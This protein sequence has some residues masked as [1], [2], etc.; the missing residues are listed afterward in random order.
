MTKFI[1]TPTAENTFQISYTSPDFDLGEILEDSR[2]MEYRGDIELACN[3][4]YD[5]F[6]QFMSSIPDDEEI[7]L[8]WECEDSQNALQ[9]IN[10]SAID[11]FLVG[12]FE[13]CAAMLEFILELDPEDH[14]EATKRLAY[15]YIALEEYEL[16]DEIINDIS[17]KHVEKGILIIWSEYRRT[18]KIDMGEVIRM[19]SRFGVYYDEF[20]RDEHPITDHYQTDIENERPTRESL[21]RELW[22][23]TEHLWA[24]H[25]EFIQS[26]RGCGAA[27]A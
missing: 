10:Q 5:A 16:Y 6:Q 11:H 14:L 7:V 18:G 13:M 12:D 3:T 19:K 24:L 23:Q 26:L 27:R 2:K 9:L 17:D 4:R 1:L 20:M 21:A 25:P 8:D 22:L 15:S